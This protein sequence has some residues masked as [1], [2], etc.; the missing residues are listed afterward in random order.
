MRCMA[1][2]T[3]LKPAAHI[4]THLSSH[5]AFEKNNP[6]VH[7]GWNKNIFFSFIH[8]KQLWFSKT[9]FPILH[10]AMKHCLLLILFGCFAFTEAIDEDLDRSN[11][12]SAKYTKSPTGC[13]CWFDLAGEVLAPDSC[14]CCKNGG[15]QCGNPKQNWCTRID[16][17]D[18]RVGCKG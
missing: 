11:Q 6:K 4:V 10:P 8:I 15:W 5:V 17:N 7:T 2:M 16:K 13:A 9:H 18:R 12:V 14:A 3:S 1:S